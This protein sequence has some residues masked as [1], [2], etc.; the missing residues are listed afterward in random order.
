MTQFISRD[1]KTY[2]H[3]GPY[4]SEEQ[5]DQGHRALPR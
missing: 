5:L 1:G 3:T 4:T 2:T